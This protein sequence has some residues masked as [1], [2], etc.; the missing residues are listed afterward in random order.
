MIRRFKLKQVSNFRKYNQETVP[1]IN[2]TTMTLHTG[3]V[4]SLFLGLLGFIYNRNES[5]RKEAREDTNSV[6]QE[7][8]SFRQEMSGRFDAVNA[9]LD[10][11]INLKK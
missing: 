1:K 7:V 2:L 11:I 9:R 5:L 3:T 6:R 10:T 4:A 8:S